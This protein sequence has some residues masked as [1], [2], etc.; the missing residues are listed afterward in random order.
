MNEKKKILAKG[1]WPEEKGFG[2][3]R[4]VMNQLTNITQLDIPNENS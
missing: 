4:L 1:I 2:L 3:S